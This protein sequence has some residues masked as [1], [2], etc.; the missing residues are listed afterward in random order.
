MSESLG[1]PRYR[2]IWRIT[3][4]LYI[5]ILTIKNSLISIFT[6][7]IIS[8]TYHGDY[9]SLCTARLHHL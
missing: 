7:Y 6:P 4:K 1:S 9:V 8:Q 5:R 2:F 3:N